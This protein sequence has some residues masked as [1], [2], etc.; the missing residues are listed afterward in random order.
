MTVGCSENGP[1]VNVAST[2]IVWRF[3]ITPRPE[4]PVIPLVF[5][6]PAVPVNAAVTSTPPRP[7]RDEPDVAPW[8]WKNEYIGL[9]VRPLNGVN[10]KLAITAQSSPR[11]QPSLNPVS[12]SST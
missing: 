6:S 11:I 8:G 9:T 2:P 7:W 12:C 3:S 1:A 5:G 10:P 4:A